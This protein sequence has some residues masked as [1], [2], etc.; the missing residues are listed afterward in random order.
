MPPKPILIRR[1]RMQ[2]QHT[3]ISSQPTSRSFKTRAVNWP[4]RAEKRAKPH[5]NKPHNNKP[6][7]NKPHNNK[8]HN[9]K[10]H[11]NKPHNKLKSRPTG[12]RTAW[13]LALDACPTFGDGFYGRYT[14]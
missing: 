8:P 1:L 13:R 9:N 12:S 6:H 2:R 3:A 11:N 10:P 5:N 7:N 14:G 4:S